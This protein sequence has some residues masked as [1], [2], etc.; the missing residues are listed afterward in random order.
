MWSA[1]YYLECPLS[2]VLLQF[3][4]Q[5]YQ[6]AHEDEVVGVEELGVVLARVFSLGAASSGHQVSHIA[7]TLVTASHS[8]IET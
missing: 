7:S 2:E 4:V 1:L 6:A 3:Y 8:K 5:A